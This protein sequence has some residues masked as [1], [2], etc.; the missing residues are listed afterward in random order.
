MIARSAFGACSATAVSTVEI[1]TA[2]QTPSKR[3]SVSSETARPSSASAA[4]VATSK[5]VSAKA[6]SLSGSAMDAANHRPIV[7]APTTRRFITRD[8][9][10]VAK[11]LPPHLLL[12][13]FAFGSLASK[14][15]IKSHCRSFAPTSLRSL[16]S[17]RLRHPTRS[18]QSLGGSS[19]HSLT[20]FVRSRYNPLA[21]SHRTAA[22]HKPPQPIRSVVVRESFALSSVQ[23]IG[24]FLL[25]VRKL[26]FLTTSR[27]AL[28]AFRTTTLLHSSLARRTPLACSRAP[29]APTTN[30]ESW[31]DRAIRRGA[32]LDNR[33]GSR[34]H[35]R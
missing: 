26:R 31:N 33:R 4:A 15:W 13:S 3:S 19:A 30:T 25:A 7:P 11:R 10:A 22:A 5:S 29:S 17:R 32:V 6:N 2:R 8:F 18:S 21:S 28:G 24:D 9:S 35:P 23:D 34:S 27:K 20:S 14:M 12:R 16:R 1:G